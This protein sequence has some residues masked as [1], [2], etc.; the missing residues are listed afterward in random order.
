MPK[1]DA[2]MFK[3]LQWEDW[4]GIAVGAWLLVS[5]WVL[6]YSDSYPA[7]MNAVLF[8]VVLVMLELLNL[9]QHQPVEEWM[10]LVAGVWLLVAPV[11]L[12][13]GGETLAAVN[14][15][16][17]GVLTILLAVWALSPLDARI[18]LWWHEHRSRH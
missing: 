11:A 1:E 10:D 13:F 7:T 15:I 12:G 14:C 18:R 5:P 17:V 16:S 3:T 9:D 8:G 4:A 6:G 2:A